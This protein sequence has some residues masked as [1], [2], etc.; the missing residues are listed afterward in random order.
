MT[1]P[2][3]ARFA[4]LVLLFCAAGGFGWH[5]FTSLAVVRAQQAAAPVSHV[6]DWRSTLYHGHAVDGEPARL[7]RPLPIADNAE[8]SA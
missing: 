2:R 7:S 8:I 3:I 5:E 1:S 4:A 6:L